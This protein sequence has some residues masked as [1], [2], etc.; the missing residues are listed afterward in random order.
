M[1]AG[2]LWHVAPAATGGTVVATVLLG[3]VRLSRLQRR[4]DERLSAAVSRELCGVDVLVVPGAVGA[5]TVGPLCPT[6]VLGGDT[7]AVLDPDELRAVVHHEGEHQ[8]RW[9]PLWDA[10][11]GDAGARAS[12]R[13]VAREIR[14][15]AAALRAGVPR[16]ALASA[17]LKVPTGAHGVGFA[18]VS[19]QRVRAL[20]G[21]EPPGRPVRKVAPLL[22][23]G[24]GAIG[25][26]WAGHSLVMAFM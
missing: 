6:I 17:L 26:L 8:R 12:R 16:A 7:V 23:A 20:L 11:T 18:P 5:C 25:C 22:G 9:D 13:I 1:A 21:D 2:C 19:E 3:V 15:D 14:A 24:A 10:L 4:V